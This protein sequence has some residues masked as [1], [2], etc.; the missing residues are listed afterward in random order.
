MTR[1]GVQ[2]P[3]SKGPVASWQWKAFLEGGGGGTED[4]VGRRLSMGSDLT[5]AELTMCDASGKAL[6]I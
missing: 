2:G 6:D 4:V 1:G 5:R 3:S